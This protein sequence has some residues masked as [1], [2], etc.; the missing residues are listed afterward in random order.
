MQRDVILSEAFSAR[1]KAVEALIRVTKDDP[2]RASE[3]RELCTEL[4]SLSLS[5]GKASTATAYAAFA[6]LLR[7]ISTLLDWREAT[8]EALPDGERF[9]RSAKARYG[10]WAK[11]YEHDGAAQAFVA[12][13]EALR[14]VSALDDIGT[15]C[16]AVASIPISIGVYSSGGI[17]IP[18]S[19]FGSQEKEPPPDELS[20]AFLKFHIDGLAASEIHH[21]TP[22]EVHDLEVEVRVSRWPA[23]G[24]QLKLSPI[25]IEPR[26]S[27]DFPAF[28]FDRPA[29]D[30]PYVL[31]DRGRALLRAA[32]GL[33]A[34]PF[35]FKYTA[36]FSP[37][38]AEQP[39]AVVGHRTLLIEG[40]DL[41]ATP[42]TGYKSVDRKIIEV[43]DILRKSGAISTSDLDD[44][45]RLLIALS[46]LAGR[47]VQD[48]EYRGVWSEAQFQD[49]VRKELRRSPHIGSELDEHAHASGG[50]TDLSY[51]GI[52]VEL[53]VESKHIATLSSCEPF[54]EQTASYAVAKGRKVAVLCLL[55]CSP[56][57]AAASPSEDLIGVIEKATAR[58]SIRIIAIV[59]Q[60][61][62]ARPSSLSR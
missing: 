49:S 16:Q 52:P 24:T 48:A 61:N 56:K 11:E 35:E 17:N 13:S 60:G 39:V 57:I 5:Y 34:R 22:N 12:A 37:R 21:V 4:D 58:G 25:S 19:D 30:P 40:L 42:M 45:L 32:Q 1:I 8:L 27:Y 33:Q 46:H 15:L 23:V 41:D 51:H 31:R 10:L 53:K 29:G 14:S 50:I 36:E 2:P 44:S 28:T 3:L 55:D 20:V 9:L 6:G 43:R 38:G 47:A 7:I 18:R 62:L 59:I 26:A 54:V